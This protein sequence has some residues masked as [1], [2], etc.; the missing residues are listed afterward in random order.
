MRERKM[1]LNNIKLRC[2]QIRPAPTRLKWYHSSKREEESTETI[3][4]ALIWYFRG[5]RSVNDR[6]AWKGRKL[7]AFFTSWLHWLSVSLFSYFPSS[8]VACVSL[9]PASRHHLSIFVGFLRLVLFERGIILCFSPAIPFNGKETAVKRHPSGI[10]NPS[11]IRSSW[12][13]VSAASCFAAGFKS[14][15]NTQRKREKQ[16]QKRSI[17]LRV[18]DGESVKR[19]RW[20]IRLATGR[21]V[22][23]PAGV[24]LSPTSAAIFDGGWTPILALILG[25]IAPSFPLSLFLSLSLSPIS[26]FLLFACLF[27]RPRGRKGSSALAKH[28]HSSSMSH[29]GYVL[30]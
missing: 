13:Q 14:W 29:G 7:T 18:N 8:L 5:R 20:L 26:P 24:K 9:G 23:R 15:K 16:Q 11:E 1:I 19:S 4:S 6:T 28:G 30:H 27:E 21:L 25:P 10:E 3:F 12:C 22:E 2:V 17:R